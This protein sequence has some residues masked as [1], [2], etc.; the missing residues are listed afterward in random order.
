MTKANISDVF[1]EAQHSVT[2]AWEAE[3]DAAGAPLYS[4]AHV[5]LDAAYRAELR[6]QAAR[7]FWGHQGARAVV[8]GCMLTR[9]LGGAWIWAMLSDDNEGRPIRQWQ[10]QCTYPI[11]IIA[12]HLGRA[13]G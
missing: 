13:V 2:W 8:L 4:N 5:A 9:H 6:R 12:N 7:A 3:R 11:T 1:T 10:A